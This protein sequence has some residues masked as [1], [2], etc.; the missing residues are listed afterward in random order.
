MQPQE[1]LKRAFAKLARA[2][3]AMDSQAHTTRTHPSLQAVL[4][5][6]VGVFTG[7]IVNVT[8]RIA[9]HD[10]QKPGDDEIYPKGNTIYTMTV[11]VDEVLKGKPGK[12]VVL[13]GESPDGNGRWQEWMDQRTKFLW[14]TGPGDYDE[15]STVAGLTNPANPMRV[16]LRWT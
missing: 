7:T 11:K 10:G 6:A 4:S 1:D 8:K 16:P 12:T 14:I 15:W 13:D 2:L 9:G 5:P 3:L